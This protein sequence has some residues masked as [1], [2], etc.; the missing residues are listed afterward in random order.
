MLQ[1]H[2]TNLM[3]QLIQRGDDIKEKEHMI[4]SLTTQL[5]EA[6]QREA[7]IHGTNSELEEEVAAMQKQFNT[8]FSHLQEEL[9]KK[10]AEVR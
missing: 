2:M 7:E 4:N 6:R 10:M 8:E 3:S 1:E 9:D 5:A